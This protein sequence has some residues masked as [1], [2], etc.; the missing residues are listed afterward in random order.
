MKKQLV[1]L[2]NKATD[3]KVRF[4]DGTVYQS[5]TD[6]SVRRLYPARVWRG[7]SERR[8]NLKARREAR[9]TAI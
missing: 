2:W 5:M 8:Q 1:R 7:K 3:S 6:G 9:L 4:T